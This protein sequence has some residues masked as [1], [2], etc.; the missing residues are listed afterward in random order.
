MSR[1]LPPHIRD[2]IMHKQFHTQ[3]YC[4]Y[5]SSLFLVPPYLSAYFPSSLSCLPLS[6]SL[7]LSLSHSLTHTHTHTQTHTH[8]H[9]RTCAL[10]EQQ[11]TVPCENGLWQGE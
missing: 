6:L 2:H 11:D 5:L 4:H 3:P 1:T 9:R 8:T 10:T 7:C